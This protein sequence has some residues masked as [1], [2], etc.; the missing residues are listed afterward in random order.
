MKSIDL[1]I[2]SVEDEFGATKSLCQAPLH[3][4]LMKGD[5]VMI[6][7]IANHVIATVVA[8]DEFWDD[9]EDY[10][11]RM[12]LDAFDKKSVSD[13]QKLTARA[14]IVSFVY[15]EEGGEKHEE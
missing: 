11:T 6:G 4:H 1:V 12:V 3:S 10:T 9:D 13:V 2:V 5:K 15:D 8:S 7:T 14:D